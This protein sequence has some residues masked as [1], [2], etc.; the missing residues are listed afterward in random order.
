MSQDVATFLAEELNKKVS[1]FV[2]YKNQYIL[3]EA[4]V[5][6]RGPYTFAIRCTVRELKGNKYVNS[7]LYVSSIE[8]SKILVLSTI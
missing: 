4:K 1:D 7:V 8:A 3:K 5:E 2:L 6:T